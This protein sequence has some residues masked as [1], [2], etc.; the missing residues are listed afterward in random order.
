MD[1]TYD[2]IVVGARCAGSP[3]AMLLARKGYRVLLVDKAVF[4]ATPCRP[5][6]STTRRRLPQAVELARPGRRLELPA[7]PRPTHRFRPLRAR[8]NPAAADGVADGYAPRRTILDKILVDAATAAGV[9]VRERFTVDALVMDGERVTGV[10]G[11][12]AGGAVVTEDARIVVGADGLHS[13]V[14]RAVQAPEYDVRP[15]FACAY[16][17]YWSGVPFEGA[18]LYP[19]PDRMVLAGG[20]PTTGKTLA[21][22]TGP[23]PP[24]T[25]SDIEG[26]LPGD[27]GPRARVR[28]TGPRRHPRRALPRHR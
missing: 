13:S 1:T 23:T 11:H 12:A 14:A 6:T 27:P 20:P 10:R 15:A 24:S 21:I 5:T 4:P 3:T 25:R 28:R 26:Q 8:R 9:E 2:A 18:E 7:R 17:S 16:Y 19:R 22:V